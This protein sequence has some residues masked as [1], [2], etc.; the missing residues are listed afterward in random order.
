[1]WEQARV[2]MRHVAKI[3]REGSEQAQL[4][5]ENAT[6]GVIPAQ[7]ESIEGIRQQLREATAKPDADPD[8]IMA[9]AE[10]LGARGR[11]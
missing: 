4:Y 11:I 6:L 5:S 2:A 8:E 3:A 10:R 9:L 1:M 7:L